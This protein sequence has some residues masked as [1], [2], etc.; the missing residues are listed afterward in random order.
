MPGGI[1]TDI[2]NSQRIVRRKLADEVRERL[3]AMIRTG[4]LRPGDR[5]PSERDLMERFAVG[6]PAVREALQS[7]G[8]AG[9]IEINPKAASGVILPSPAQIGEGRLR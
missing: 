8:S 4:E 1:D 6:R 3:L 2:M 9:L 7:L 5:L